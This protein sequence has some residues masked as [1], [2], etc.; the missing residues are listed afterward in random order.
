VLD[1]LTAAPAGLSVEAAVALA[2][3]TGVSDV[4]AAIRGSSSGRE[5]ITGGFPAD[6]ELAVALDSSEVIP[7][8]RAGAFEAAI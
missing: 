5:L 7:L 1:G 4:A 6:V 2:T 8:L 3:L